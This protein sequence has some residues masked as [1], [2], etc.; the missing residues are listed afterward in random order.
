MSTIQAIAPCTPIQAKKRRALEEIENA[1]PKRKKKSQWTSEFLKIQRF[2]DAEIFEKFTEDFGGVFLSEMNDSVLKEWFKKCSTQKDVEARAEDLSVNA[3]RVTDL[4]FWD[5]LFSKGVNTDEYVNLFF[6]CITGAA[7]E[8][9][10][11]FNMRK[12]VIDT[13]MDDPSFVPGSPILVDF[14]MLTDHEKELLYGMLKLHR[15]F[16]FATL[17]HCIER[18]KEACI[19]EYSNN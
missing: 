4:W 11:I 1:I 9:D 6:D 2:V 13:C 16:V 10:I 15:S 5:F 7:E 17:S 3:K 14:R 8:T 18:G 12:V 19:F